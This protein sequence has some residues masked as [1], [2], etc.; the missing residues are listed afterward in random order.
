[1]L[2]HEAMTMSARDIS[3]P[4]EGSRDDVSFSASLCCDDAFSGSF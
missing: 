4:D 2:E 3:S 1:M